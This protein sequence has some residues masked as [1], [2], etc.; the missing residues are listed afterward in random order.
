[1]EE[2]LWRIS[3]ICLMVVGVAMLLGPTVWA[4]GGVDDHTLAYWKFDEGGGTVAV[5]SSPNAND[6]DIEDAEWVTGIAGSGLS[7]DGDSARVVVP[8]AASLHSESGD[9]TI[10]AW[11]N[12][13]SSPASWGNAGPM[14]FKQ[15]AYQWNVNANGALWFGIWGARLETIGTYNFEEH[16]DEWHHTVVTFEG[17]S[18][19]TEIY[20]DGELNTEGTVAE[21]VDPSGEPL[22][23]G[24]KGDGGSY[25]HGVIDEVRISDVVRTQEEIRE[26]MTTNL[27]V[28]LSGKLPALW[29]MLKAE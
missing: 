9:I 29:G 26:M 13:A 28:S 10:E 19:N 16:L 22:Y 25:F 1:M 2:R 20:V 8:D 17:D 18:Q 11:I 27:A 12:V 14:A 6:G 23:I 7:F 15:D 5:D 3:V 21:S 4:V 24:F